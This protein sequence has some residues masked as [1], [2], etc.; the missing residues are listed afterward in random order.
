MK[1]VTSSKCSG[2]S[3]T[4]YHN[5][6]LKFYQK[7]KKY[8]ILN[9]CS[10]FYSWNIHVLWLFRDDFK[11]PSTLWNWHSILFSTM[12]ALTRLL[13][14]Q[15]RKVKEFCLLIRFARPYSLWLTAK[16][17]HLYLNTYVFFFIVYSH[18]KHGIK[19]PGRDL[20][21]GHCLNP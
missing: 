10:L 16:P 20:K 13:R 8:L 3:Y 1:V 6:W 5:I 9:I 19:Y 15:L 11:L 21:H 17:K 4:M 12:T 2:F 14:V 18:H 7:N